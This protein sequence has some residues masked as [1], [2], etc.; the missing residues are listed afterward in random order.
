MAARRPTAME[1]V[2]TGVAQMRDARTFRAY[3]RLLLDERGVLTSDAA[4]VLADLAK[5]AGLGKVRP[6][7]SAEELN[8]REGR[9]AVLLHIFA[10]IDRANL[11]RLARRMRET[12]GDE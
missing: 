8:F 11:E 12:Q 7:A 10:R 6:G 4:L 3:R 2:R 1:R 5:A 9:R